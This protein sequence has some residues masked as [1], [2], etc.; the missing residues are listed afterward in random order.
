MSS[1]TLLVAQQASDRFADLKADAEFR[2][3]LLTTCADFANPE[4]LFGILARRFHEVE[5]DDELHM[6]S[7]VEIQLKSVS[8]LTFYRPF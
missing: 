8:V 6:R 1:I 2:D 4:D 3:V 5:Q 7:R